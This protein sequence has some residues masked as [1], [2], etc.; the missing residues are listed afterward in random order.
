MDSLSPQQRHFA[1]Q[2]VKSEDTTPEK[3]VRSY[4]HKQGFRYRLHVKSLPGKPDIVLPKYRTIIDVRGCFW[5]Q[6]VSPTCTRNKSPKAH[7]GYWSEKFRK[8]VERDKQHERDWRALGWKVIVVWECEA[9]SEATLRKIVR[10][11]KAQ[12]KK[13]Q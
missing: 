9:S 4:L 6:H 7:S 3:V 1:M 5:H 13:L 12:N 11:L 2:Q 10:R 8:N